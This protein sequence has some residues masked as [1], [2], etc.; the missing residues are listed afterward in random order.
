MPRFLQQRRRRWYA[1]LEIPKLLR[2]RF[3]K[4][5]FVQSLE[6]ESLSLAERRVLPVVAEWKRL[7]E[8]AKHGAADF[9][10]ELSEW[11]EHIRR[12]KAEGLTPEEIEDISFD[13]AVNLHPDPERGAQ[14]YH[15]TTGKQVFLGEHIDAYLAS[16]ELEPKTVDMK[17]NDINRFVEKFRFDDD[18]TNKAVAD[19]VETELIGKQG[20]SGATC[21]RIISTIRGYW[22]Y[23]ER[24]QNLNA[25]Y[26]FQSVVPA[27]RRT[28]KDIR[29][30]RKGFTPLDYR[31]L[32]QA[33]P[34]SDTHLSDLIQL[35][36]YTGCRIEELCAL[37][38][39]HVSSDR[40][41]IE[42][43]KTEAGWREIPLHQRIKQSV[44]RLVDSSKDGYLLSGLTFN[45]YG[46]RSNAI[47]KRF[48]RLKAACGY[49]PD[50][51]F[52]SFRKGVAT[53]LETALVPENHV[54]RLLGHDLKTMSYGLYSGGVSFA[55]LEEAISHLDWQNG[56][57]P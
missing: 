19:W 54:A 39:L 15:V 25:P 36:A 16:Q 29:D 41:R 57:M 34:E 18:V 12:Y 26:P 33:V 44:A 4:P 32:L 55:V 45:K 37:K 17:R 38:L 10:G 9:E 5:R 11:R 14:L 20:L 7:I 51:V 42:D 22:M 43:A 48:G 56:N 53:Q 46:D 6:T 24:R 28:K 13:V 3:G 23:L 2:P 30:K 27:T 50:Y 40:I 8:L 21:R 47:G 35:G 31:R 52:H 49:G 1:V